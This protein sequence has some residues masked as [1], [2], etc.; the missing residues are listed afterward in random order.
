[1]EENSDAPLH[2]LRSLELRL[3]RCTLPSDNP[4]PTFPPS[5]EVPPNLQTLISDVVQLI[6]SG[7]YV[8]A[9]SSAAVKSIFS[10][11]SATAFSSSADSAE[12]FYS[13]LV[14]QSVVVF[15][16]GN[17]DSE[18]DEL[19]K[20]FRAFLVMAIAVAALLAFTQSN[21]TGPVEKMPAMPLLPINDNWIEWE[22]WAQKD[23]MSVGSDVRGKFSNLQYIV[24][25]KI[26]LMKTK[27]LLLDSSIT[28]AALR[29]I[30]WWLARVLLIH[31]KLL[32]E[33]SSTVFDLLQ[34][35]SHESLRHF[36]S[37]GKVT[38][39]WG[40]RLSEE[41]ALT[42]VS[43]LHL[44][45]GMMEVTYA[46]V[47]SSRLHFETAQKQSKLDFSVSGALG[48]RTMHQVEPK[49]Q[50][51][52]VT[53]KSSDSTT[54]SVS[55]EMQGDIT[56]TI[57]GTSLQHPPET[58]EASDVLMAPR[59]LEDKTSDSG[60]QAV[61]I[62]SISATQ[63]KAIQQAVILAQCL[64]I[65]KSARNDELQHYKMAPYMEAIDSQQ[66]S[67]FTIKYFCNMLR[68]RW[69]STRSRTKQRAL[70]MMEKLV[71]SIS[72][73]SPGV[74]QRMFY[75]FAV[76]IPGI[77][78]LRKE[79]G[80]L[81]VSCRLIGEAIKVYE[82]LE[83]W[84]NLIYCYRI[85]EKKAA[86]VELIKKQLLERPNDSRL[87]C[88]LGDVTIDDSCY[89]KALD[90]SG[91]KSARALRSLAR[92]AY[93]RGDYEKSKVLWESAMKLNSLYPDGWFAL[94]AAALKAR[95]VE[96][97]LDGFTRAVQLDPEN[98]EAWNN[99]A[100]LH[101]IRKKSKE[102]FVA[103]K[104]AL[105]FKRNNWQ[106]WENFSQVAA[107]VGNY[108]QAMDAIQKVLDMTSNKRF[109]VDLLERLIVE[110][111][112]QGSIINS[113]PSEATGGNDTQHMHATSDVN[114]ADKS[115]ISE[116]LARKHEFE[117]LMQMLGKILQQIVKSSGGADIWGLYAR[118]HKLKGDL[119][120]CSEALLKQVRAYQGSDLWKDRERF[121]KFAHASLEL[122]KVYQEL[123]YQ[124]GG[125]RELFAAEMHVKNII[126]QGANF[127]DTQEYQDLLASLNQ[128]QKALQEDSGAA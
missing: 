20:C 98:G 54:G 32:D 69:E 103:F 85:L 41:D 96:K 74:V 30:C 6:E 26:L 53:G 60:D 14:P 19:E 5:D 64:S 24:L 101:M 63:L 33:C 71:E 2:M 79:F 80:D 18:I 9:L 82:D 46:R 47:D 73:P 25:S 52:L 125:R 119:T 91:N 59:I 55:H 23:I 45:V 127:S 66:S 114:Y 65:E 120:M 62:S 95:D 3:L 126:K 121:V 117:H 128:V 112:K 56:T 1:M 50:L 16:N 113:H 49:A 78:A 40:Q 81:L 106:M 108:S 110:I 61:Q 109:D 15:V 99:V 10:F 37:L 116:D 22:L 100:C 83:L 48:F 76:N 75:S 102:A 11:N 43:M 107:D 68:V 13:E 86:A 88:S 28:T 124:T 58:Q 57:D 90:I 42:I 44:E 118:W 39:Y 97:A 89:E 35:Y 4:L 67:P 122:C 51:L 27:D 70:L 38:N 115:T 87:W 31:Q 7:N 111:E 36:G 84:D 34:V 105:K 29:S 17:S 12:L 21:V 8:E 123:S 93:N 77:P 104:E 94:G 92:S 72:E